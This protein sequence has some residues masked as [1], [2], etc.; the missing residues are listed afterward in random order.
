MLNVEENS[1]NLYSFDFLNICANEFFKKVNENL[2]KIT[3]ESIIDLIL[4]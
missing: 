2:L 3:K 4:E 1:K